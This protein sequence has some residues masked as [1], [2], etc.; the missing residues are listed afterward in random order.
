M[1]AAYIIVDS[2]GPILP[3]DDITSVIVI[4]EQGGIRSLAY[5][6]GPELSPAG[7]GGGNGRLPEEVKCAR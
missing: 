4:V 1:Y 6:Q 7:Q 3:P 5:P 2:S